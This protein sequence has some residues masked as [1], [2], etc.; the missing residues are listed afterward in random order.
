MFGFLGA[1]GRAARDVEKSVSVIREELGQPVTLHDCGTADAALASMGENGRI[2]GVAADGARHL[3]LLGAVHGPF[4][5]PFTGSTLDDPPKTA[6]ALL[7]RYTRL[8]DQFLDGIVGHYAVVVVDTERDRLVLARDPYAGPRIFLHKCKDGVLFSTR[9]I[10][11][12]WL[13]GEQAR[14]DRSLE[15][16]LLGYEFLP[17]ERTLVAGVKT[18]AKGKLVVCQGSEW[19]EHLVKPMV[20]ATELIEAAGSHDEETVVGALYEAFMDSLHDQLPSEGKIGVLQGGF[21]SM[22]ITAV[23]KQMG[24]EVETFTFRYQESGYTQEMV[25]DFQRLVG[26]RHNWVDIT[27]KVLAE[28][29]EHFAERFNQP[30]GQAHYLIASAEAA[31]VMRERGVSHCLSGDGCDGLF[32][33][34][35]TV[36]QRARFVQ[37]L[38]AIGGVVSPLILAAGSSKWLEKRVGHPYRFV[39]NIARVLARP[40][41]ARGHIAACTL[42]A[43]SLTFL[44]GDQPLQEEPSESILARLADGLGGVEPLRLAYMGKGRVGL[45]AAKLEGITRNAGIP[46]LSPYLHPRMAAVAA[47]IPDDLNRPE[48]SERAEAT[49]KYIFMRMVDSHDLLPKAFVHQRKMSPVTA[50]VDLWYW[51]ELRTPTLSL[52][53]ELPFEIDPDYVRSLV[54]PKA[55]ERLFRDRVGISRYVCQAASLL[56]TY[57][58]FARHLGR[59]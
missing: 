56:A 15:D 10:D 1:F 19:V 49:G 59:D 30:V 44:R 24:R 52:I 38:S 57:A 43:T 18:L 16:F 8:G 20:P 9:L 11:F 36:Y 33:G 21:D 12:A 31:R 46:F 58:G 6:A 28:G 17:D 54:T 14:L 26:I 42:D 41:P 29:I 37:R 3:V 13:L 35:P 7:G 4:P 32:L 5:E 22:L 27:P 23:L 25:D 53:G 39:R 55:A 45:N 34:Y 2:L 40:Q 50:P 47:R 51:G 48:D